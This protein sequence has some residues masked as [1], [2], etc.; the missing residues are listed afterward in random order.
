LQKF[1]QQNKTPAAEK[2]QTEQSGHSQKQ[3]PKANLAH[4]KI[5]KSNFHNSALNILRQK[6]FISNV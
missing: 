3:P 4:R 1:I 6:Q 2:L 5:E